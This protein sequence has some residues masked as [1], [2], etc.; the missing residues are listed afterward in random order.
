MLQ[1]ESYDTFIRVWTVRCY[2]NARHV[3]TG[4]EKCVV[5]PGI[6]VLVRLRFRLWLL[7]GSLAIRNC[8]VGVG[9]SGGAAMVEQTA[10]RRFGT[11]IRSQ[12]VF[13]DALKNSVYAIISESLE[14]PAKRRDLI[15][16]IG[17]CPNKRL[18]S[19]LN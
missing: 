18:Y 1:I 11:V 6:R 19:R 17:G 13:G 14:L 2:G 10:P 12:H 9:C 16:R 4:I 8:G 3:C 7:A 15:S 5:H